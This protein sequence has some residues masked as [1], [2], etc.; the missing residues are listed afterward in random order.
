MC[1]TSSVF[2]FADPSE[3]K[4]VGIGK[5]VRLA[6]TV[7]LSR[8][9]VRHNKEEQVLGMCV[10]LVHTVYKLPMALRGVGFQFDGTKITVLYY[11]KER[12]DFR[13]LVNEL[14]NIYHVRIWLQKTNQVVQSTLP[15]TIVQQSLVTGISMFRL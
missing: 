15:L 8:L 13:Q 6:S 4:Q 14:F 2:I 9:P 10:H 11:S 5:I 7:E 3:T 12:V 1:L